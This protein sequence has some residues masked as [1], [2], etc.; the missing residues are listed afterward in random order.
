MD[1]IEVY[2]SGT[3]II[4]NPLCD[5]GRSNLDFGKG[6]YLTD[7]YEQAVSWARRKSIERMAPGVI[8][9]YLF[10]RKRAIENTAY[11][12]FSSYDADWLDFVIA[13]RSGKE[14]SM[15]FDCVEGGIADDRVIDT[16]NLYIQGY[17]GKDAALKNLQFVK[18]NNQI[19][20]L[21]QEVI[22]KYLKFVE[23]I[24]I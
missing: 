24:E 23:S 2:H 14:I 3:E 9:V 20:I 5:L 12:I 10:E 6:F 18:P 1:K 13:C 19:C 21:N 16:V 8:N 15:E 17:I 4:K 22:D 7:I 11:K